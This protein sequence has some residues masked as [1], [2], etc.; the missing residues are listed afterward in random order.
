MNNVFRFFFNIFYQRVTL[1]DY[2][3]MFMKHWV[4][5]NKSTDFL[6]MEFALL[7]SFGA[8]FNYVYFVLFHIFC[9]LDPIPTFCNLF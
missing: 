2:L 5:Y 7:L 6:H 8:H 9:F 3:Q 1:I 4:L